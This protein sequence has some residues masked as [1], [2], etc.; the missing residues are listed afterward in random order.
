MAA[1]FSL[2]LYKQVRCA[3]RWNLIVAQ[4]KSVQRT[5][6]CPSS[7][8]DELVQRLRLVDANYNSDISEHCKELNQ[9]EKS[10]KSRSEECKKRK[11]RLQ[12]H[13]KVRRRRYYRREG[14]IQKSRKKP[15]KIGS[16]A[17]K[18]RKETKTSSNAAQA[19]A[20]PPSHGLPVFLR[21]STTGQINLMGEQRIQSDG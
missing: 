8:T 2:Q 21:P 4:E 18:S 5:I 11:R 17:M 6:E 7:M 10:A 19:R 1:K 16:L 13:R 9:W 14:W 3:F 20:P 15:Q 12:L